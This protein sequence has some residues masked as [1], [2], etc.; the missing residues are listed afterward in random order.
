MK[1]LLPLVFFTL[2]FSGALN[3]LFAQIPESEKKAL[4]TLYKSTRGENWNDPWDLSKPVSD[5][6]G[7]TV[8]NGHVEEIILKAEDL[9]GSI[10]EGI[11]G[12]LPYLKILDLG[13]N[14]KLT[15]KVPNDIT[16]LKQLEALSLNGTSFTGKMPNIETL[17]RLSVID[18]SMINTKK[19][20]TGFSIDMPE[21]SHFPKLVYFNLSY[22]GA[23]GTISESIGDCKDLV[24]FDISGN[25]VEGPLPASL[26]KCVKMMDF[27]VLDNQLSGAIPD[28]SAFENI[29]VN[30]TF[31]FYGRFFLNENQFT[32][33]I[34]QW[35]TRFSKARGISFANNK[36]EGS[37]PAD[38]SELSSLEFLYVNNNNLTGELP[39]KLPS[40]IYS[41]DFSK[42]KFTGTIPKDWAGLESLGIVHLE[43]NELSGTVAVD[44]KKLPDLEVLHVGYNRFS[45]AD[46]VKWDDFA[47]NPDTR[48]FFGVQK[49]YFSKKEVKVASGETAKIDATIPTPQPKEIKLNYMWFNTNTMK[50][51]EGAPNAPVFEIKN[52]DKDE[53]HGYICLVTTDFFGD[54]PAGVKEDEESKEIGPLAMTLRTVL[55]DGEGEGDDITNIATP[56]MASGI[57]QL[58]V[59]G[60]T[61]G[62]DELATPNEQPKVYPTKVTDQL[63]I[64]HA[65]NIAGVWI[66]N[67]SGEVILSEKC[68]RRSS[69]TIA[70]PALADGSYFALLL[71]TDGTT[72]SYRFF[73]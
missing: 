37:L 22:A 39:K 41:L 28:L 38:L 3:T 2:F 16:A 70:L 42:N 27:S 45:F 52:A 31:G 54:D 20:P 7:V 29:S 36:L 50:P 66:V 56:I 63:H 5:W 12:A 4:E 21:F 60:E 32:G 1:K 30:N 6:Y 10:P 24:F 58:Y 72:I 34:P 53:A 14:K 8:E 17:N 71:M 68:D 65:E 40:E 59:D 33:P 62:A 23:K 47:K 61:T 9:D 49:P 67:M 13:G 44:P 64:D 43:D 19:E 35:F 18:I 15:G 46:F 26:G 55:R 57:I 11:L 48:F 51:I 73:K 25:F 69:A